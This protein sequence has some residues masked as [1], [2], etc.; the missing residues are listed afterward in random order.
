MD[1]AG[2]LQLAPDHIDHGFH[3]G[4]DASDWGLNSALTLDPPPLYLLTVFEGVAE[5]AAAQASWI[6]TQRGGNL[7]VG[8][9]GNHLQASWR[10]APAHSPIHGH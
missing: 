2:S 4:L 6:H 7:Q 8:T 5:S 3:Q 1:A 10:P 9:P